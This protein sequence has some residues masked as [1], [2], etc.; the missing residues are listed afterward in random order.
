MGQAWEALA[1]PKRQFTFY[2]VPPSGDAESFH[3]GPHAPT[4]PSS[5]VQLV[6]RL[7]LNL[8][9][10]PAMQHLHHSDI[11]TYALTRLATEYSSDKEGTLT[12]LQDTMTEINSQKGLGSSQRFARLEDAGP[13]YSIRAPKPQPTKEES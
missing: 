8:R 9:R 5:D 2:V 11:L 4:I 3:I 12:R 6:H 13:G 1:E 7:W 10:D